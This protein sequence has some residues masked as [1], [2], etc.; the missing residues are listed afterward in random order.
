MKRTD[1]SFSK[2]STGFTLVE[3]AVALALVGLIALGL[4][5][6]LRFGQQAYL[7]TTLRGAESWQIVAAQRWLRSTIESAY[8]QEPVIGREATYGL[9]GS[10]QL[11]E[12]TAAAPLALGG[13]GL[14]RY[15]IEL[16]RSPS[17]AQDIVVTGRPDWMA[18]TQAHSEPAVQETLIENVA[19]VEWAYMADGQWRNDWRGST[20]LPQLVRLRVSFAPEDS[21]RWPDLIVAPRVTDDANC[22]FDVVAQRC[23]NAS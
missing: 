2:A 19:A 1:L 9:D 6:S 11:L 22:A 13:A 12:L 23:R 8:P 20:K 7:K 18:D 14:H 4:F 16:R 5:E 10:N 21:R 15:R 17:G 3:V